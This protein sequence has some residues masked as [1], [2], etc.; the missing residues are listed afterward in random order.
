M[1]SLYIV[2]Y[3]CIDSLQQCFSAPYQIV[4]QSTVGFSLNGVTYLDGS[5]VLREDIGEGNYALLCTTDRGDCCNTVP[6]SAGQFFFPNGFQVPI[7]G[8][9]GSSGYYRTRGDQ[10]IRLN[11]QS[12][13]GVITGQFR[14]EIPPSTTTT[15]SVIYINI[16][17]KS[18]EQYVI[19]FR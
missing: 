19:I 18:L 4:L 15:V 9:V 7:L 8:D 16:G 2:E 3:F 5:T 17:N 12:P 14:C 10:L 13:N 11:R 6:T 1:L